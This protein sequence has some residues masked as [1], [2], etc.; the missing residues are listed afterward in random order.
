MRQSHLIGPYCMKISFI[1][2]CLYGQCTC[3][4]GQCTCLSLIKCFIIDLLIW[5]AGYQ[6]NSV[7]WQKIRNYISLLAVSASVIDTF[8]PWLAIKNNT[9]SE[10]T[11]KSRSFSI[12]TLIY[13]YWRDKRRFI[14]V[15]TFIIQSLW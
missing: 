10:W 11:R 14:R 8:G 6:I 13:W 4:Y 12:I 1:D 3:L 9:I 7:F 2:P 15:N 5:M